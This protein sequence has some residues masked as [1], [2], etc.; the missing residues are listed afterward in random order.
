MNL[1]TD[2]L[3]VEWVT[4]QAGP[5]AIQVSSDYVKRSDGVR[6]SPPPRFAQ[7]VADAHGA[8]LPTTKIVRMIEAV[9]AMV[10]FHGLSSE[11]RDNESL[12]AERL[13]VLSNT[14]AEVDIALMRKGPG[15]L[16]AGHKKDIVVGKTRATHPNKVTIYGGVF[17]SGKRVQGLMPG[18]EMAAKYGH[19]ITYFDYSHGVRLVKLVGLLGGSPVNL[20]DILTDKRRYAMLSGQGVLTKEMLRY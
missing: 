5:L 4:V 7:E 19:S 12:S 8:M 16:Y 2:L 9:A 6:L 3:P 20:V 11:Q 1:A 10:P 17:K 15:T 13:I 18:S 14:K